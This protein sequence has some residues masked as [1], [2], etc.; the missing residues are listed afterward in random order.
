MRLHK[1]S[2]DLWLY[3]LYE[4]TPGGYA[5]YVVVAKTEEDARDFVSK[6]SHSDY[7]CIRMCRAK[8]EKTEGHMEW[9]SCSNSAR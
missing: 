1:L 3:C 4:T 2:D 8:L 7:Q 6:L 5:G 9:F